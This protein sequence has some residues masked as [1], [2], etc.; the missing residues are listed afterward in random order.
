VLDLTE[1]GCM[2]GGKIL[3]DLGADV[4]KIEPPGG[5]FS[6]K[7]GS[8]YKDDPNPEKSL[9]WF[10]YNTSKRSVV[11]HRASNFVWKRVRTTVHLLDTTC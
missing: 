8:F 5:S 7:I 10:A 4:L 9:F 1:E 6:R 2:V 3:A 11:L